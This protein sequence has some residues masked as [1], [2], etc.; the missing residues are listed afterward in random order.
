MEKRGFFALLRMTTE[1][2]E[3]VSKGPRPLVGFKGRRPLASPSVGG[4]AAFRSGGKSG[5]GYLA[6]AGLMVLNCHDAEGRLAMTA[7]RCVVWG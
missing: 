7:G 1:G 6:C 3:R 4:V 2:W 5:A